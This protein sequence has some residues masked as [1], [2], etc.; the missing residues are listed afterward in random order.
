MKTSAMPWMPKRLRGIC[1]FK[2]YHSFRMMNLQSLNKYFLLQ[3]MSESVSCFT[4]VN[5]KLSRPLERK[6]VGLGGMLAI[7]NSAIAIRKS[8]RIRASTP[9]RQIVTP[10]SA[11]PSG[12][13]S[14]FPTASRTAASPLPLAPTIATERA[15]HWLSSP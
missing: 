5:V 2:F 9:E 8:G 3:S 15:N 11:T 10:R 1:R 12:G 7:K 6:R 13:L 4:P 14:G